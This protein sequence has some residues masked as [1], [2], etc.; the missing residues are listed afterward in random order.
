MGI[1]A[2]EAKLREFALKLGMWGVP[3][4]CPLGK[5]QRP[6]LAW[7]HDGRPPL[8]DFIRWTDLETI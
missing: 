3:R 5:M 8:A 1:A 4:V 2:S 6:P 7:R